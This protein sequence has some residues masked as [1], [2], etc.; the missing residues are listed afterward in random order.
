MARRGRYQARLTGLASFA[1]TGV[2]PTH[3]YFFRAYTATFTTGAWVAWSNST[4]NGEDTPG[5]RAS[6]RVNVSATSIVLPAASVIST[7][8][9]AG[10]EVALP[11]FLTVPNTSSPP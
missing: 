1:R 11:I 5:S 10:S 8:T 4:W 2:G 3:Y 6:K 7:W 9:W